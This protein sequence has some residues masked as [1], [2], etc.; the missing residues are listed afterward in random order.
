MTSK[1]MSLYLDTSVIGGYYDKEFEQY[2]HLL[3]QDVKADKYKAFLSSLTISELSN[4]PE[5]VKKLL[6]DLEYQTIDVLPECESLADEYIKE[7][8]VGAT[9]RSDCI[10]IATATI[11]K[12]DVLVSWNLKHIVNIQRIRGYNSINLKNGYGQLEIRSPREV[13]DHELG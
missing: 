8:V 11:N 3:F 9:S 4:A 2:T 7:N 5:K 12:I 6:S 1:K 13:I 10:H